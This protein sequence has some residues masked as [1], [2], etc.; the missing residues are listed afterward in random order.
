M[1]Q[2]GSPG[3]SSCDCCPSSHMYS[4]NRCPHQ[5]LRA[6]FW[7]CGMKALDEQGEASVLRWHH[8]SYVKAIPHTPRGV[9][10]MS[11]NIKPLSKAG[12]I[13]PITFPNSP[14]HILIKLSCL[15]SKKTDGS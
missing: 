11:V 9:V 6:G 7:T 1:G 5:Q 3:D 12:F 14:S 4:W 2:H 13:I 15:T 8:V 10:E